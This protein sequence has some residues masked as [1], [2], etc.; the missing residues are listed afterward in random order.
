MKLLPRLIFS[1]FV[2][3][4]AILA[5]TNFLPDFKVLGGMEKLLIIVAIFTLINLFIKPILKTLL[6]PIIF[7]TLG[8]ATILIN[9]LML[10]ILDFL[11][12]DVSITSTES[13]I[14]ATLIISA[15][16]LIMSL[17]AKSLYKQNN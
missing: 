13:L 10:Y 8:L 3:L 16:N 6:A 14:Y 2:N 1:F 11:S 5:A 7:I 17:S 9:A 15:I 12:A 4:I